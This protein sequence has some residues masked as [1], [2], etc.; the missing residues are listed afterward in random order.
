[1]TKSDLLSMIKNMKKRYV[2]AAFFSGCAIMIVELVAV[3]IIAPYVGSSVY[4]WTSVM[5]SILLGLAMGNI[6]GGKIID[7]YP[8]DKTIGITSCIVGAG[9]V[10]IP[11]SIY[12]MS[13]A[14]LL[15]VSFLFGVV[16]LATT[17]LIVPSIGMGLLYPMLVKS[18]A[19][20]QDRI[21]VL[22]GSVSAWSAIGSI[23]GTFATGFF[24]LGYV[25]SSASIIAIGALFVVMGVIF[26]GVS[27]KWSGFLLMLILINGFLVEKH[28]TANALINDESN[29]YSIRVIEKDTDQWGMVRA[30]LLDADVHSI[31][32]MNGEPVQTYPELYALFGLFNDRIENIA[33]IGEGAGT[34]TKKCAEYY[35]NSSIDAVEIDPRVSQIAQDI[36]GAKRDVIQSIQ[37]DGRVFLNQKGKQ[38][39]L[40]IEDAFNSFISVPWHLLTYEAHQQAKSRLRE[41]GVYVVNILSARGGPY[42]E[43]F[44]AVLATMNK[45]FDSLYVVGT[46]ISQ[47]SIQN[48]FLIGVKDK[49]IVLDDIKTKMSSH[50]VLKRYLQQIDSKD[51]YN[52]DE[53]KTIILTDNYAP[54][55]RLMK[56]TIRAYSETYFKFLN[57]LLY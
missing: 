52:K 33:V 54:T 39:D 36:F 57:N 18:V 42:S 48:I 6:I 25:G 2:V 8:S 37:S 38:Y 15:N 34:I 24:L 28:L 43:L 51:E 4:T 50:D 10:M 11:Y 1:M 31:E 35:K 20:N 41:G 49:K 56:K 30:L 12:L 27:K 9:I 53:R 16:L 13:S 40:I 44:N 19:Q 47:T 14:I 17:T 5:G 26:F 7:A 55:E 22:S 32:Q 46:D 3:R 21:G 23:I 29:Y 45:S